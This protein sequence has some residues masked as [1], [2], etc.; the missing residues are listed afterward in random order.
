MKCPGFFEKE[1]QGDGMGIMAYT[2]DDGR[3]VLLCRLCHYQRVIDDKFKQIVVEVAVQQE[4][5][6]VA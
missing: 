2:H 4:S 5:E 3:V 1:C 6:Q